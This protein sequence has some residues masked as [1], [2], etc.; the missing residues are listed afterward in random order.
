MFI[1]GKK[2]EYVYVMGIINQLLTLCS[3]DPDW[4]TTLIGS[5]FPVKT[6]FTTS[7]PLKYICVTDTQIDKEKTLVSSCVNP[8][9]L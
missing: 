3:H 6:K 9:L 8:K 4:C 2:S 5:F 7:Q 1:I